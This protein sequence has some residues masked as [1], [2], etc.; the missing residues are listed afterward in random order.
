MTEGCLPGEFENMYLQRYVHPYVDYSII[1]G[2][3]DVEIAKCPSTEDWIK[4]TWYIYTT[5]YCSAIR[6]D[7]TLPF[8]TQMAL[9]N[10]ML[11]KI[12]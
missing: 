5:G 2:G 12:S 8:V 7:E 3:Q 6:N 10:I 11:S 4:K 9:E 1:H